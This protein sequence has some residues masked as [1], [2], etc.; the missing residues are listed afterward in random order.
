MK[1]KLDTLNTQITATEKES[2]S[3]NN[4]IN[5]KEKKLKILEDTVRQL[6]AAMEKCEVFLNK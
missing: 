5:E 4:E 3:C 1:K 2:E 6:E